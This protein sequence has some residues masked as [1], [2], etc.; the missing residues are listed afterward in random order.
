MHLQI[1]FDDGSDFI[2]PF[3]RQAS[4]IFGAPVNPAALPLSSETKLSL[5]QFTARLQSACVD[6]EPDT[7][8]VDLRGTFWSLFPALCYELAHEGIRVHVGRDIA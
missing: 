5:M 3:D 2:W 4:A 6:D 8:F 7:T 1:W